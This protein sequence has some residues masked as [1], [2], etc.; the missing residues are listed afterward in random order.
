MESVSEIRV[1]YAETDQMGVAYHAEYL[2][3]CEVARTDFIRGLGITYAEMERQHVRL[4]VADVQMRY[5]HSA[6]YDDVVRITSR[7]TGVRSRMVTFA[8]DLTRVQASGVAVDR[9]ATATTTL[10]S[11]DSDGHPIVLPAAMR[12]LLSR[13]LSQPL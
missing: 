12:T 6:R 4:A 3:W 8:Y 5:L 11:V 7:L 13:G 2:V 1:R 10:V 9:I